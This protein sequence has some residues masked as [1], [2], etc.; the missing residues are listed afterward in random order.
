MSGSRSPT[1]RTDPDTLQQLHLRYEDTAHV[2]FR[3]NQNKREPYTYLTFGESSKHYA[4]SRYGN[5]SVVIRK[6]GRDVTKM[7]EKPIS[8]TVCTIM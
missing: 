2:I 7:D 3:Q 5:A 6:S 8:S 4:Y 1:S